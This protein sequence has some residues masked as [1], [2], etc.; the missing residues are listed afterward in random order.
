MSMKESST[1]QAIL[2]EGRVEGAV[3]EAKTFLRMLGDRRFGRPDDR[4]AAILESIEDLAR[5]EDLG[6]RLE[7]ARSWQELL[8]VSSFLSPKNER[9]PLWHGLL[10]KV[11]ITSDPVFP[12][13]PRRHRAPV[14]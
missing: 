6:S 14:A 10:T 12:S 4:T 7:A 3:A 5:L 2:E 11:L 8:G 1:Y 13:P 9:S